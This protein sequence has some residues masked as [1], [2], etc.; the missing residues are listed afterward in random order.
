MRPAVR[1]TN[2]GAILTWKP[3]VKAMNRG[4][5]NRDA[6]VTF[7]IQGEMPGVEVKALHVDLARA[8]RFIATHLAE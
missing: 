6:S 2:A 7:L 5:G 8:A 1:R 3:A 4:W